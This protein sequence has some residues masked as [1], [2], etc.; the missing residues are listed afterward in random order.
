[1]QNRSL[2]MLVVAGAVALIVIATAFVVS[3]P[4][5]AA[6]KSVGTIAV[7][8]GS[9]ESWQDTLANALPKPAGDTPYVAPAGLSSTESLAREIFADY[10]AARQGGTL[11]ASKANALIAQTVAH[12][13]NITSV[14]KTYTMGQMA[15]TD[16]L[17]VGVYAGALTLALKDASRVSEYELTTFSR[18]I[19]GS[20]TG[21]IE[22]LMAASQVYSAIA[23]KL[24]AMPVPPTLATNHLAA[25]NALSALA[26]AS[27]DLARWNGD[28]LDALSLV[29]NFVK[30]DD[31]FSGN[32][33]ALYTE[34]R[35][36]QKKS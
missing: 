12:N 27:K 23:D 7:A 19:K 33:M 30:A 6:I 2:G 36:L 22:R 29:N 10:A 31:T 20:T 3:R 13:G 21:D 28:P 4:H 25:V 18:V 1:M 9:T 14:P 24:A 34:V 32:L 26:S 8:P 11:D 17:A 5:T 35:A 16:G 15:V